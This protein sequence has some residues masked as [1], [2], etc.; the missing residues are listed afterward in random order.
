MG[1]KDYKVKIDGE[2]VLF[3]FSFKNVKLWMKYFEWLKKGVV[4]KLELVV[5]DYCGNEIKEEYEF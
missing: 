3:G 4:Y 1:I 2:F 5:I